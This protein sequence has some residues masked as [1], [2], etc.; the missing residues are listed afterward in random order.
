MIIIFYILNSD[1]GNIEYIYHSRININHGY[2]RIIYISNI[3]VCIIDY[4][5][6]L[7]S[8]SIFDTNY[9]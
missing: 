4:I 3:D 9:L 8:G 7:Y 6:P 5:D 2:R 1:Y